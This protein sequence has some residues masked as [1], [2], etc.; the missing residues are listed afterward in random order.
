MTWMREARHTMSCTAW[1]LLSLVL[2]ACALALFLVYLLA[3]RLSL[4]R[5]GSTAP[6][7]PAVVMLTTW[8][9][10]ANA[11]MLDDTSPWS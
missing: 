8:S 2:L 7:S 10:W 3:Q 5:P 1:S 4:L 6:S 9:R 11:A